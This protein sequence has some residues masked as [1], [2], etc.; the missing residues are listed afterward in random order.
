[1]RPYAHAP[2]RPYARTP[3]RPYAH[4]PT[5]LPLLRVEFGV[6]PPKF[7]EEIFLDEGMTRRPVAAVTTDTSIIRQRVFGSNR[8]A[9]AAAAATPVVEQPPPE[10]TPEQKEEF[11]QLIE[12]VMIGT[13]GDYGLYGQSFANLLRVCLASLCY[14]KEWL[15]KLPA[16]HPFH[17]SYLSHNPDIWEKL[18]KL[19]GP[20]KF[21]GDDP[22]T[23]ATGIPPY[24]LLAQKLIAMDKKLDELPD[25]MAERNATLMDEKGCFAGNVTS[26]QLKTAVSEALEEALTRRDLA[27]RTDNPADPPQNAI[28]T[29][30]LWSDGS[31]HRLPEGYVLTKKG[32][33]HTGNHARTAQQAFLRWYL[34]DYALGVRPP[35]RPY[36]HAPVRPY[37]HAP[38]RPYAHAPVSP[39]TQ[40]TMCMQ[41]CALRQVHPSDFS[42]VNQRKRFCD[43][44]FL[45]Q[46]F[47]QT[48]ASIGEPVLMARDAT[49]EEVTAQFQKVWQLHNKNVMYLHPSKIKRRRTRQR[50]QSVCGLKV[51]TVCKEMR[52]VS[53]EAKRIVPLVIRLQRWWRLIFLTRNIS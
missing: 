1:M 47:E 20:L 8:I 24:T 2:T 28:P 52:D 49:V 27:Q 7:P 46:N 4:T 14:H 50:P 51:S 39:Y 3:I 38:I 36:A 37:A 35:I 9:D 34:P 23:Q 12:K 40:S 10:F 16:S 44:K 25:V 29:F 19:V 11:R 53:K 26:S 31:M 18:R 42:D 17:G 33:A 32:D 45:Y 22:W 41:V 48:L 13:Y 5:G 6:L 43:W 15:R 21:H 30:H